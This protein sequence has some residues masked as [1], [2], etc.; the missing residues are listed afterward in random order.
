MAY[1]ITFSCYGTRLHGHP[2]GS[3]DRTHNIPGSPYLQPCKKRVEAISKRLLE[4]R[5]L[6]TAAERPVVLEA[7]Q[8][9]CLF[10]RWIAL[11]VQVRSNHAHAVVHG[12]AKPEKMMND[13][14][15][16]ATRALTWQS[17]P[18]R[19]RNW[20]EHGS[21]RYLWEPDDVEAALRYV[22]YMQG[23][24]MAVYLRE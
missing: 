11:A 16:Y 12:Y 9:V 20:A 8:E 23:E 22:L 21:T 7:L 18:G 1:L 6:L 10:R 3:V 14:K 5:R 15:S 17:Q 2:L 13:F 24:P 19:R 4:P